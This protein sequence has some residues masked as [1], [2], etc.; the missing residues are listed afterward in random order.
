MKRQLVFFT[1]LYWIAISSV[2]AQDET[3]L[4]KLT[5]LTKS[6]SKSER[7]TG[8][9]SIWKY[10]KQQGTG[11]SGFSDTP[12][13][14]SQ[15]EIRKRD[16]S[17][18]ELSSIAKLIKSGI[19][20]SE[21]E[22]RKAA[23]IA[24]ASAP[25][26]NDSVLA[27]I[28]A[29]IKSEDSTVNWYV[30][31]QKT[32]AWPEID[33]VINYLI[34]D[35]SDSDFNKHYSAGDLLRRYGEDARPYSKRIA[36][37][38]FDGKD[39]KDRNLKLFVLCDIGLADDAVATLLANASKLTEEQS[40]IVAMSLLENTNA[41][42]SLSD[43]RPE[44]AQALERHSARLFPFLCKHQNRDHETRKWLASQTSLPANI[45]GMLGE[46][47]FVKEIKKLEASAS[48]H[49]QSFLAACRRAC[50]DKSETVVEVTSQK[51]VEFRPESAWP[52][53]DE[54]RRSK[55]SFGHG[56]GFTPVMVTGEIRGRD[57]SH[58]KDVRFFR[59][60][61]SM[62][63]GTKQNIHEPLMYDATN[64]RF[65]NHRICSL[66]YWKRSGGTWSLSDW[67]RTNQ[68]RS[69]RFQTSCVAVF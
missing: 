13:E 46:P 49:R 3:Q 68:S 29:G 41:L 8:F 4:A 9:E 10:W 11:Y 59:T 18:H 66:Q 52:N 44:L 6:E 24:L 14:P 64:G 61:D 63:L 40:G 2:F 28:T 32:K 55:T 16:I 21:P 19:E 25:R 30:M 51:P 1:S 42:R 47:R 26:S 65:F 67:K 15:P 35:L 53:A 69:D 31:Q 12:V 17:D 58:P 33:I 22:V 62:L 23:A 5:R 34:Q 56:D 60:N 20:D 38:I 39:E 43:R 54:S 27:S 57:G 48:L 37:A 45:M 7:V 36:E 50:G